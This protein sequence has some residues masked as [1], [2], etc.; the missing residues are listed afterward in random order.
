MSGSGSSRVWERR[1]SSDLNWGFD[2]KARKNIREGLPAAWVAR[3]AA[4]QR[5]ARAKAENA[6]EDLE[7]PSIFEAVPSTNMN[8]NII[9]W[10]T[11]S[12]P[13]PKSV[14]KS[15]TSFSES[16]SKERWGSTGDSDC[17]D[18]MYPAMMWFNEVERLEAVEYEEET[19]A[20]VERKRLREARAATE[21]G[22]KPRK[23]PFQQSNSPSRKGMRPLV[24]VIIPV[25]VSVVLLCFEICA[26]VPVSR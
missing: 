8:T 4:I 1:R 10:I 5:E 22:Q 17:R 6:Q 15:S 7:R 2:E 13:P 20:S 24:G 9:D 26:V 12:P 3:D 16:C 21:D 19:R 23:K 14:G 25:H 11:P 18:A